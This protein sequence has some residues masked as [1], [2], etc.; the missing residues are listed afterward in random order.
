MYLKT[1]LPLT[2]AVAVAPLAAAKQAADFTLSASEYNSYGCHEE[3]QK[4]VEDA[5]AR[6]RDIVMPD[7]D[8]D[9]FATAHN[10]S[11]TLQPGTILKFDTVN[12]NDRNVTAGNTV[13]RMQYTSLDL[14]GSVVPATG[15]I[16]FPQVN[17]RGT[18][19]K[20]PLVAWAHGTIGLFRGCAPT[21]SPNFYDYATWQPIVDRGYAVVAT[22]YAGLGNN[23]T[24]HRYL[25]HQV[26][27]NDVYYSV[28]AARSVLGHLLTDEWM[29]AGHS[30]GG[31]AAWKL[32][33][34]HHV[35]N[36]SNYLGTVALSPATYII[37]MLL[38]SLKDGVTESLK[39]YL[40]FLPFAIERGLP[41]FNGTLVAAPMRERIRLAERMQVCIDG[42]FS[43]TSGLNETELVDMQGA[44]D[45]LPALE[46]WQNAN[47]AALG[48]KSPAPVLVIQGTNDSSVL[49]N[50][51]KK[52]WRN[53]CS[54]GNEV[55]LR[56]YEGQEHSPT[57]QASEPEWLGWIEDRFFGQRVSLH[58]NSCCS[59]KS[60]G[61]MAGNETK[62]PTES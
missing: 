41:S 8:L 4:A 37:D 52:A 54:F 15:F 19:G 53:S 7:F 30:Q 14:N 13:Y 25:T 12:A 6:D 31:G 33:E 10:F 42:M 26:H 62:T 38:E 51:T 20:F 35:R 60:R 36:D 17:A 39:G 43:M 18:E 55:H 28:T 61:L 34:S 40:T 21:N 16:A 57:P 24:V 29:S 46:A 3:C 49:A 9:F 1:I 27:A 22:D 48:D 59:Q 45:S 44:T 56:L 5:V 23:Y 58:N 11:T 32:A 47:S 2:I 50:T